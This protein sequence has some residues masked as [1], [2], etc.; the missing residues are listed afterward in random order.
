MSDGADETASFVDLE[1]SSF[2]QVVFIDIPPVYT[3][4]IS[5][6][7]SYRLTGGL[8]PNSKDWIG[9]FKVGWKSIQSYSCYVWV[10]MNGLVDHGGLEPLEQRVVFQGSNFP[11]DDGEFYQFCYVDSSCQ[12]RGASTPF[13]IQNSEESSLDL[14]QEGDMLVVT[15]Q[16]QVIQMEKEKED[17]LT[18]NAHL[19]EE[20]TIL[21]N[22]LDEKLHEIRCLRTKLSELESN[23]E[24]ET[25][26]VT[27]LKPQSPS[28]VIHEQKLSSLTK[29]EETENQSDL[30]SFSHIGVKYEKALQKIS[31]LKREKETQQNE[32]A[33]L[34]SSLK[35]SE[36]DITRDNDRLQLLQVD[37]QSSQKANERL[38]AEVEQQKVMMRDLQRLK[39]E[40]A[41]LKAKF[42][43]HTHLEG[44]KTTTKLQTETL[45]SQLSETRATLLKEIQKC[46]E[47]N[48]HA[49]KVE[50]ELKDLKKQLEQKK[51]LEDTQRK[52]TDLVKV[53]QIE[54]EKLTKENEN[55]KEEVKSL[56]NFIAEL[57]L[58]SQPPAYDIPQQVNI[59]GQSTATSTSL[60]HHLYESIGFPADTNEAKVCRHCHESFPDIIEEE[61]VMHEQSHTVCPFCTLICDTWDQQKFED[62]VYGHEV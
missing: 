56:Q 34:K 39:D 11:V 30:E 57:Q 19:F 52:T 28:Q 27:E 55:L 22:E 45:V 6:I 3:P 13:S 16:E 1:R 8:K 26:S 51:E 33:E 14:N 49:E 9:I 15:T 40:N 53:A 10:D 60:E 18:K 12:V 42:S 54:K 23:A 59:Q 31:K 36:Q 29:S 32:I 38:L 5:V 48:K 2:S 25:S 44:D 61:L 41:T 43:E 24:N 35:K 62:H 58:T 46:N 37:M 47:A 4:Q 21:K 50:L 17:L 7:C 20:N